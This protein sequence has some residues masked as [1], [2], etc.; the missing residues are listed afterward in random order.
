MSEP[1]PVLNRFFRV[2]IQGL[3]S[4]GPP[5]VFYSIQLKAP[6]LQITEPY[7]PGGFD[8]SFNLPVASQGGTLVMRRPLLKEKTSITKWYE[9]SL[10]E[11]SFK[12][13]LAQIFVLGYDESIITE[14]ALEGIYPVA[15]DG[16]SL[17][18][19]QGN[20]VVDETIKLAYSSLKR[21]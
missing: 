12:P 2:E 20:G 8:T 7:L 3:P 1:I 16:L 19:E 18:I 14:W 17:G 10:Q 13:T 15:L 6:T 11:F 21:N 9:R 4:G 5:E